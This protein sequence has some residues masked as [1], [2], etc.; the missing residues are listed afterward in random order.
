MGLTEVYVA[1][2]VD[3]DVVARP[4]QAFDVVV[5]DDAE[6]EGARSSGR[7]DRDKGDDAIAYCTAGG[8]RE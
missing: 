5:A 4:P 8:L 6:P 3:F 7:G 1:G 2:L